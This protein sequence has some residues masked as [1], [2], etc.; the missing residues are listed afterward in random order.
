MLRYPGSI[1]LAL[2]CQLATVGAFSA[3]PAKPTAE[4]PILDGQSNPEGKASVGPNGPD[5]NQDRATTLTIEGWSVSINPA[6]WRSEPAATTTA[7]ALLRTQLADIARVV[8]APAL[9][10]LR[11]TRLWFSPEYLGVR[12]TAEYHPDAVWLRQH[13][14]APEMA[15]GVEFT[16]VRAYERETDR[17]PW[18]VLHELAHGYHDRVLGFDQAEIRAAYEHAKANR[19]YDRVERH[20]GNGL[21]NTFERA[22]AM[23]DHKE[24]FA[25]S[26][27]AFFGRNDFYPWTRTDL[28]KHDPQMFELLKRV[29]QAE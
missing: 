5:K 21:P 7:L 9:A 11:E 18:F 28:E 24:Y 13:G 27:E 17:M 20:N 10:K 26:S 2:L 6:L 22:Y 16:N 25:E 29:W 1:V 14:R 12:P 4:L 15:K 8:P 23:T 3:A 19:L